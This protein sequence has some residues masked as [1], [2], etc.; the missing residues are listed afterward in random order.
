MISRH[1]PLRLVRQVR[2]RAGERC[3]YCQLP[4]F[5]QEATF[6]VDH[7]RPRSAGGKT[8]FDTWLWP[9]FPVRYARLRESFFATLRRVN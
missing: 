8:V 9:V 2:R 6:H 5:S 4:Q 7:V 1:I 3:E